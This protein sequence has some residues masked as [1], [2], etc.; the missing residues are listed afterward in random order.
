[1]KSS[2][3]GSLENEEMAQGKLRILT[4]LS[5]LLLD[6]FAVFGCN[7]EHTRTREMGIPPSR[8]TS[9]SIRSGVNQTIDAERRSEYFGGRS[10]N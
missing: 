3:T 9:S 10:V 8:T 2:H 5:L 1:V 7:P 6:T 4:L